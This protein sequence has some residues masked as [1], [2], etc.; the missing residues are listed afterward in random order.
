MGGERVE[1]VGKGLKIYGRREAGC[2]KGLKV[3]E[4]GGGVGGEDAIGCGKGVKEVKG[5]ERSLVGWGVVV[6]YGERDLKQR[7]WV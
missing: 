6:G 7:D 2:R 4:K 5:L 3:C 1:E